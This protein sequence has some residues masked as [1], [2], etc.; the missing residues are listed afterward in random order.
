MLIWLISG[1]RGVKGSDALLYGLHAG[2]LKIS[3]F[4]HDPEERLFNTIA[5]G[6]A[7][8]ISRFK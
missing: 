7:G 2:I 8:G 5:T 4:C 6:E 3:L 1:S